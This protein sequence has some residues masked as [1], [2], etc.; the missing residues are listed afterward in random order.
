M[1]SQKNHKKLQKAFKKLKIVRQLNKLI[2]KAKR[3]Q[4]MV[5]TNM[6]IMKVNNK[7]QCKYKVNIYILKKNQTCR[8][9]SIQ[10]IFMDKTQK[11]KINLIDFN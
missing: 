10:A 4:V 1:K 2:K 5:K 11:I 9:L 7:N 6:K 3:N 8:N